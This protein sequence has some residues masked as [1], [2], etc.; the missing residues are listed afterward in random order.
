[1]TPALAK[2]RDEMA[3][4]CAQ[5]CWCAGPTCSGCEKK[6]LKIYQRAFD[7]CVA[8][9]E[10]REKMLVEA[11]RFYSTAPEEKI[12]GQIEWNPHV[13]DSYS[14]RVYAPDWD[15]DIQDEPNEIAAKA[16]AALEASRAE[17]EGAT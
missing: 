2:R 15:G 5:Y 12:N 8:I 9:F 10:Q 14:G 3:E 11:L 1:M 6:T 13:C 4:Q 7:E 17:G 16:L